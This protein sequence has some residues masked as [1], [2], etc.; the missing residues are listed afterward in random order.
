MQER[1]HKHLLTCHKFTQRRTR[2]EHPEN[3]RRSRTQLVEQKRSG[4]TSD[5]RDSQV[6]GAQ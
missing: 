4:T 5:V 6:V 3:L 1:L 2:G